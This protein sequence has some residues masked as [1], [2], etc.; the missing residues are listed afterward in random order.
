MA[1]NTLMF[2]IGIQEV[3]EKIDDIRRKF[4]SFNNEYGNGISIKLNLQS[5][6]GDAETLVNA[7][8]SVGKADA[9][10]PYEQ[11]LSQIKQK[12]ES[13]GTASKEAV[14]IQETSIEKAQAMLARYRKQVFD[15][16]NQM[17]E[18]LNIQRAGG[19]DGAYSEQLMKAFSDF[20]KIRHELNKIAS[21]SNVSEAVGLGMSSENLSKL[22][23][24]F[25]MLKSAYKDV[26]SEAD[27]YNKTQDKNLAKAEISIRKLS[28]AFNSLKDYMKA[29]GGSDEMKRLQN[30]IQ[31]AIQKMRQLMNAGDYS[32]AQKVYERISGVIKQASV[33]TREYDRA[34]H[35]SISSTSQLTAEEMRL[36]NAIKGSTD[37]MRSQSQ[38]LGDL[39]SLATQYLGVWG[40]QGFLKNVIE[41]G[42]QLEMQ[43]MSI[44]AILGDL[45]HANELFGRIKDLAVKSPFGVVELDQFTKQLSAYGFKYSELF[46]MTKRLADI[47]AGAGTEVS[48][49][50]LALGH[51]KAEGALTGYT[52]RQFAM[53]NIPMIG[54]L[55]KRLTEIEG[56]MVTAAEIR[57]RVSKK[58]IG[59]EDV[60]AVIKKLTDEG[61]IFHN[62]QEVISES[63]K[64]RFK[65]LRDAMDIMYGE[66][67]ESPIGGV[68]KDIAGQLTEMTRR[69]KEVGTVMGTGVAIFGGM[70]AAVLAYNAVMGTQAAATL[71]SIASIR[72]AEAANLRFATSYRTLTAAE[73][74]QLNASTRLTAGE[75]LRMAVGKNLTETQKQR[76]ILA[77][78]QT[79]WMQALALSEGKLTTEDIARQVALGKLS[80]AEARRIIVS[81]YLN[82]AQKS[83][84]IT[85]INNVT[86][87]GR[88]TG[89]I[90]GLSMAFSRL[91]MALKSM[92]LNPQMWLFAI[93]G[94]VME[95]WQKNKQEN[96]RA[97]EMN[98]RLFERA[99]EGIKNT[100]NMMAETGISFRA[101][102][103]VLSEKNMG[104][105]TGSITFTPAQQ[106]TESAMQTIV[107]DWVRYIQEYAA[108]PNRLINDALM[109][110]EGKVRT[111]T[112]QYNE[113]QKAVA[114]VANAQVY[115]KQVSSAQEIALA[116]TNGDNG[117]KMEW[118]NDDL[119]E[120]IKDAENAVKGYN[121]A[122]N[123]LNNTYPREVTSALNAAKGNYEFSKAVHALDAKLL[124]TEK[125]YSTQHEQLDLLL[126]DYNKYQKAVELAGKTFMGNNG[127]MDMWTEINEARDYFGFQAG[128]SERM[129]SAFTTME[130]DMELWAQNIRRTMEG[131]GWK[132]GDSMG[133]GMKQ[134]LIRAFLDMEKEAGVSADEIDERLKSVVEKE[135]GFHVSDNVLEN[136]KRVSELESYLIDV[137]DNDWHIDLKGTNNVS[138]VISKIRQDYKSAKDF[139][140]NNGISVM[141]KLGITMSSN[142][143]AALWGDAWIKEVSK[144]DKM[145]EE[146]LRQVRSSQQI[147]NNALTISN[148]TGIKLTESSSSGKVFKDKK[149]SSH[150][151]K[152]DAA[153]K[154][155][156]TR[157]EEAKAFLTEYKKYRETYGKEQAINMLEKLFPTTKDNG[158]HIVNNYREVLRSI[159]KDVGELNTEDRKKFGISIDKLISETDLSEAKEKID[160]K[161]REMERYMSDSFEK[162][163]IYKSIFEKT[164]NKNFAMSAFSNGQIWDD[165]ATNMANL[166]REKMGEKGG[167]IDWEADEQTAEDWYKKNFTNGEELFK[168]WKKIV[169]LVSGN[170][171][172]A[173]NDSADA[174]QS[175]LSYEEK[176]AAIQAKYTKKKKE[177]TSAE[178]K[179]G[180]E[181]QEGTEIAQVRLEQLKDEINWDAVF[182]NLKVYTKKVLVDVRKSLSEYLKLNRGGMNATQIKD[183]E[184]AITNL[185]EAI[186][187]KSGIFEGLTDSI[188]AYKQAVEELTDAERD[189]W[190]AV[191]IYGEGSVQ[192]Q[193]ARKLLNQA[194]ANVDNS[195]AGV[196]TARDKT[197]SKLSTVTQSLV[198]L[199]KSGKISLSEVGNTIG[200]LVSA[201]GQNTGAIG[202]LIAAI[203]AI[204]DSIGEMG[205]D[206]FIGNILDSVAHAV[207]GILKGVGNIFGSVFG[208]SHAFDYLDDVFG[209]G[210]K[211]YNKAKEEYE[212]L[213]SVWESLI[214]KKKEYLDKKWG[215]EA[216][217]AGEEVLLLMRASQEAARVLAKERLNAGASAGSHSIGYRMWKGSYKYDNKTWKDVASEI[218]ASLGGIKFTEM[219]DMLNMSAEQL[220]WIKENYVGLWS[221][222]D[223]D[224]RDHLE[225]VIEYGEEEANI[226]DKM[227]EKLTGWNLDSIENDWADLMGE[228]DNTSDKL[229]ES[230]EDKLRNAI[231]NAMVDNLFADKLEELINSAKL[232]DE[233]LNTNGQV[234][235]HHYDAEGNITD[236]DIASEFTKSEWDMLISQGNALSEEA[237]AM[238]DML[239]GVYGW[240]TSGGSSSASS[241]IKGITE[242]TADLLA[243]YLNAIRA[244]VSVDRETLTQY[245]PLIYATITSNKASLANIENH[246][247]AIMRSNETI[248]ERIVSLDGNIIGLRNRVWTLPVS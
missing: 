10:K 170:Y 135:W 132:F 160:R 55:S 245:I 76:I 30:E 91:G 171:R 113:L 27:R 93:I 131:H 65:N 48:R 142:G 117:T 43:R 32:G 81:S 212:K 123:L 195:Q 205:A 181:R 13:T 58:E 179:Y 14:K 8:K 173:L 136:I 36:A 214:D 163:N 38:I 88:L 109:D 70:K 188:S 104:N 240:T 203:F 158:A 66:I 127:A 129:Q 122:L 151:K 7:L 84:G 236:R 191:N 52:L 107:D 210:Y 56:H 147:I 167:L 133:E 218:S 176:I 59:Y 204:L 5:A 60:E 172:D 85:A 17:R 96:E 19:N 97:Q 223:S 232:N 186:A 202:T 115:M 77:R 153:L 169:D 238:R 248:A 95:L 164:G 141:A 155:A 211:R 225:N 61:G 219:K 244:D 49:L 242:E 64:A 144:G 134:A 34:K 114:A 209:D 162:Y 149:N 187:D 2:Q 121:K 229:A 235:R 25:G 148:S 222:M 11:A 241:S 185:N 54:E 178:A 140:E 45:S 119:I 12:I 199:G 100:Q 28:I 189:Y 105:M 69:W 146:V 125:R 47:S 224:F 239:K 6:I 130:K 124:E 184:T 106:L 197:L 198:S 156:K 128:Q 51:V 137:C 98:K 217:Q 231:L 78:E 177:A 103:K 190:D 21:A 86:T 57:K 166:L 63:V 168:L 18:I 243:S 233:Y 20:N 116:A 213:L 183:V 46:D 196:M 221:V 193:E 161:L 99:Q 234:A 75:R 247:A 90:N 68:L 1:N 138:D 157:L 175:S 201:L 154:A 71:R 50:A 23:A 41:T 228:M 40:A 227:Q 82:N 200:N 94:T 165:A 110:Q 62:M 83:A 220:Q 237:M 37:S 53:N 31:V 39:K 150:E 67:A 16:S 80:K 29:N 194:Q 89:T 42:G 3:K 118:L 111:L 35:Q 87:Y 24:N 108:T 101:N 92:F 15:V 159:L 143:G 139:I 112:E 126:H 174:L 74:A 44:G 4:D 79:I 145:A 33:A 216:V 206:R 22:I 215:A 120:N 230:L 72:S 152:E 192:A 226:I 207:G 102:G 9:L 208:D 182:G 26:I 246:T 73:Q 180:Y